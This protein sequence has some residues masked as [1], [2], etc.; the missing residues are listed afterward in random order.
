M[1]YAVEPFME[2][3]EELKPLL[4]DHWRELALNQDKVPLDVRWEVYEEA[5][6]NNG[7]LFVTMRDEGK[8]AGYFVG[9][10]APGLHYRACLTLQMDVFWIHPDYRGEDSLEKVEELMHAEGLFKMVQA[11]AKLRGVQRIF[12][13]SKLHKDASFL[14]EQLGYTEV[15]RYHTLWVGD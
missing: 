15:E 6:K 1:K 2:R 10:V 7:L 9:F 5:C 8:L 14:F 12:A 3:I 13:G 11:Q 4:I